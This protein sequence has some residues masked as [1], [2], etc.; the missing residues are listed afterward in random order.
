RI[1]GAAPT[2]HVEVQRLVFETR[3]ATHFHGHRGVPRLLQIQQTTT[4]PPGLRSPAAL[5]SR[6]RRAT[7]ASEHCPCSSPQVG[8]DAA[9]PCRSCLLCLVGPTC[10]WYTP[11]CACGRAHAP[12]SSPPVQ[13]PP[14]RAALTSF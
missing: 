3:D 10:A 12:I 14:R 4:G 1:R 9:A 13:S 8:S 11:G 5:W 6:P 7:D 2:G